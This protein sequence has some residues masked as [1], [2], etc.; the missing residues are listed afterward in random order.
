MTDLQL[1]E[2][3]EQHAGFVI[4]R[5]TCDGNIYADKIHL[6]MAYDAQHDLVKAFTW[7]RECLKGLDDSEKTYDAV[8]KSME[9]FDTG[10]WDD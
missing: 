10:D 7:L 8:S 6:G 1:I 3:L 9:S 2:N 5:L 4:N